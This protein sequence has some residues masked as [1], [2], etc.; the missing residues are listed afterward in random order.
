[1][2]EELKKIVAEEKNEIRREYKAE[3]KAIFGSHA[4]G[5]SCFRIQRSRI[6]MRNYRLYLKTA[7]LKE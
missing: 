6:S 5:T 7:S 2:T 4:R 3:I 1:M